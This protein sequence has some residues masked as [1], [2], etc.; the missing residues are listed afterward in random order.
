M[1]K[2]DDWV[3]SEIKL[4]LKYW[5]KE[6]Q[7]EKSIKEEYELLQEWL[8]LELMTYYQK[9]G[10]EEGLEYITLQKPVSQLEK[11]TFDRTLDEYTKI[12]PN[13]LIKRE[14][15]LYGIGNH[16]RMTQLLNSIKAK[17]LLFSSNQEQYL[18]EYLS[19]TFENIYYESLYDLA[20][21]TGAGSYNPKLTNEFLE[22]AMTKP[23]EG[24]TFSDS[25]WDNRDQLVKELRRTLINGFARGSSIQDMSRDLNKVMNKGLYNSKRLIRTETAKIMGEAHYKGYIDSSVVTGYQLIA[26]LDN[27]TSHICQRMDL[28]KFNLDEKEVGKN[29]PPLHVQCR[30]TVAPLI[31][32]DTVNDTRIARGLDGKTYKV[33]GNMNYEEWYQEYIEKY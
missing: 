3:K 8:I 30:T 27:R 21:G 1:N 6:E 22:E 31:D 28:E 9:Y 25:I 16:T 17:L 7:A 11:I 29:F 20:K 19:Q 5:K 33:P 2:L 12:A 15:E 14:L 23:L 4:A 32:W 13:D 18:S 24:T 26:T 10:E